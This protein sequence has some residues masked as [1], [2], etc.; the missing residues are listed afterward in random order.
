MEQQIGNFSIFKG[1][2]TEYLQSLSKT[3]CDFK[4]EPGE[5]I[6]KEGD[7]HSQDVYIIYSG[8]ADVYIGAK[9]VSSLSDGDIV[10]ELAFLTGNRRYATVKATTPV[11]LIKIDKEG[12]LKILHETESGREIEKL[13]MERLAE[14]AS[15][16]YKIQ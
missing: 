13:V 3:A 12:F 5:I 9:K 15:K 2:G 11:C 16:H 6:I 4:Y 1:V 14:D 8:N 7:K 10:G